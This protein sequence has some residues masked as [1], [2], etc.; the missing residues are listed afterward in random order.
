MQTT[1]KNLIGQ[2]FGKLVVVARAEANTNAKQR[3]HWLCRCECGAEPVK[4]GKYLLNGNTRSCGCD[5]AAMRARGNHKHGG[6]TGGVSLREYTIWRSIKSRCYV[7][8]ASN[9]RFYGA[10]GVVM[11]D[12]WRKDFPRFLADMGPCPEGLTIDRINPSG[13]YEPGNC[14]WASWELQ[15][16]NLR[17]RYA[18]TATHM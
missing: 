17:R 8:S 18:A 3:A 16:Q 13:N 10:R 5:Q 12:A 15:H 6:I 4:L 11:C 9:Y 14:R 1:A 2:R 7:K